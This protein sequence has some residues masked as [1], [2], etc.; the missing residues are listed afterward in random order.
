[1]IFR[2]TI[3]PKYWSIFFIIGVGI[4]SS[5]VRGYLDDSTGP[6]QAA[7][8]FAAFIGVLIIGYSLRLR[9]RYKTK[10]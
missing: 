5:G 2:L 8:W 7:L 1:L 4:G 6:A 10:H 3:N 9:K